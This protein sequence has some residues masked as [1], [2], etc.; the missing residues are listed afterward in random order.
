M[1]SSHASEA[2]LGV[3]ILLFINFG[4]QGANDWNKSCWPFFFFFEVPCSFITT[5]VWEESQVT[6]QG[7]HL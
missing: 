2:Q 7:Q 5:A 6:P 4:P 1:A 3:R